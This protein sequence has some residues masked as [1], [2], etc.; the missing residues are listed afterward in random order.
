MRRTSSMPFM[1]GM[2]TSVTTQVVAAARARRSSRPCRP[3]PRRPGSPR[4][5]RRPA[6]DLAHG[7][8]VVHHQHALA[9]ARR[10]ALPP[11][12]RHAD[13]CA[14]APGGAEPSTE[15][16]RSSTSTISD[17]IAVLAA[18]RPRRCWP[19]CQPRVE[20]AHHEVLLA[21]EAVHREPVA[22][23]SAG[24]DQHHG[25]RARRRARARRGPAPAA[26]GTSPT[27]RP[28]Q[29]NCCAALDGADLGRL[30]AQH[31]LDARERE[32]VGLA[33]DLAPAPPA[34]PSA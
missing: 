6:L 24:R 7:D 20:R 1:R 9:C 19:P 32:G 23:R 14:G 15:R 27:G 22:G 28:S 4:L 8:R 25:H 16:S 17:R 2:S 11:A 21:Q 26:A 10:A 31:A 34:P 5:V 33:G 18:P 13:G 12:A 29:V 3:R 30:D